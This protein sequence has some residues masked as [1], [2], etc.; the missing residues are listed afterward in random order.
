MGVAYREIWVDPEWGEGVEPRSAPDLGRN[1]RTY[2]KFWGS[3]Q[4]KSRTKGSVD[5]GSALS[6]RVVQ[7]FL[8]GIVSSSSVRRGVKTLP[9]GL[10]VSISTRVPAL[11]G[12]SSG[13]TS[14]AQSSCPS[15][16][17]CLSGL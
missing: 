12:Y 1:L 9:L 6:G 17:P 7:G 3:L 4:E 13:P 2:R 15:S 14:R 16:T 11:T 8:R 10:K 5:Y